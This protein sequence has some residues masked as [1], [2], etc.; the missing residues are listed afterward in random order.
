M[1]EFLLSLNADQIVGGSMAIA[2]AVWLAVTADTWA[3]R[4]PDGLED[5]SW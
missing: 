2:G 3:H 4:G 1:I 5:E